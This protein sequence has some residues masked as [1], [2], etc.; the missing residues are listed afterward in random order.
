MYINSL[1][2]GPNPNILFVGMT[3]RGWVKIKVSRAKN[4]FFVGPLG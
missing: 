3:P 4:I 1:L 2:P